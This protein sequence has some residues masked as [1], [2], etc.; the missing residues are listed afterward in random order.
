MVRHSFDWS[1][2]APVEHIMMCRALSPLLDGKRH[3]ASEVGNIGLLGHVFRKAYKEWFTE[4]DRGS[5]D[6]KKERERLLRMLKEPIQAVATME[7]K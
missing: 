3:V 6:I 1:P 2:E 4:A 7:E 5:D